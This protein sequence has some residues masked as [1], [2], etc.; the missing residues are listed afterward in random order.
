M[1]AATAEPRKT[2][3]QLQLRLL[4]AIVAPAQ[5]RKKATK[6]AAATDGVAVADLLAASQVSTSS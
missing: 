3:K 2:R 1:T 6:A 5:R 4:R